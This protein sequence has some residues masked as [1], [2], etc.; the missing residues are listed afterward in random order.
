MHQSI[1]GSGTVSRQGGGG[2]SLK[3]SAVDDS[4]AE[5][6]MLA[7]NNGG[8]GSLSITACCGDLGHGCAVLAW[9]DVRLRWRHKACRVQASHDAGI[10]MAGTCVQCE[11]AS[12][13]A[14]AVRW[15][16]CGVVASRAGW[17]HRRR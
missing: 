8:G 15:V 13:A 16:P 3:A 9:L 12:V 1:L 10:G 4:C 5:Q 2:A 11:C 17:L 6:W 14:R 7:C